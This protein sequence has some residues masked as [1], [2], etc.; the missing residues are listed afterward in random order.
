MIPNICHP[1]RQNYED[2]KQSVVARNLVGRRKEDVTAQ[3]APTQNLF[4]EL[5]SDKSPK[6]E[7]THSIAYKKF[8]AAALVYMAKYG[9]VVFSHHCY[10]ENFCS[11][12]PR[13]SLPL[14]EIPHQRSTIFSNLYFSIQREVSEGERCLVTRI[15]G[16]QYG[17]CSSGS[18][19]TTL[20]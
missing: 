8:E 12:S 10:E 6:S 14:G 2:S 9:Q 15:A 11:F 19:Q 1:E 7:G 3:D 17:P 20:I 16:N 18:E 5:T 4:D 13:F